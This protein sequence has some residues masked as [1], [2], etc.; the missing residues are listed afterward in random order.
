MNLRSFI[1]PQSGIFIFFFLFHNITKA[2]ARV[3]LENPIKNNQSDYCVQSTYTD[4][5]HLK[6]VSP[7]FMFVERRQD[8][9]VENETE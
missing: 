9:I 2:T 5:A 8:I 3:H 1:I 7:F 6:T 4:T